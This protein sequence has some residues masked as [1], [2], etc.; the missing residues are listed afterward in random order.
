MTDEEWE[1]A[2]AWAEYRAQRA[3]RPFWTAVAEDVW[4][5]TWG[6]VVA[7]AWMVWAWLRVALVFGL[8][9]A[10]LAFVGAH[11]PEPTPPPGGWAPHE[12]DGG[13][14]NRMDDTGC[15]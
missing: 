15:D 8:I 14:C 5:A 6:S 7:L 12:H 2:L 13:A 11:L 9:A 3:A 4:E 1:Q 10:V